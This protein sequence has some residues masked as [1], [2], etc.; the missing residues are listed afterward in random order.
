MPKRTVVPTVIWRYRNQVKLCR[1]RAGIPTQVMLAWI[2]RI[3]RSVI[4]E[5]EGQRR[6]LCAAYAL[7]IAE[8]LR[9]RVDDLYLRVAEPE[10][11]TVPGLLERLRTTEAK[12]T[13]CPTCGRYPQPEREE[14]R[15]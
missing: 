3:P 9:C 4:S 1:L 8:T 7:L 10:V 12:I 14:L 5:I 6:F 2:T 11:S 15:Q 13:P